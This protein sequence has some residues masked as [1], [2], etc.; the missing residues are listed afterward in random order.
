MSES[1]VAHFYSHLLVGVDGLSFAVCYCGN[2]KIVILTQMATSRMIL[3]YCTK[4]FL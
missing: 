3:Y 4:Y 2:E 1:R